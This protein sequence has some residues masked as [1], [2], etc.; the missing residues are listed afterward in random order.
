MQLSVNR[1]WRFA[2]FSFQHTAGFL[3]DGFVTLTQHHVDY[4]LCTDNL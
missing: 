1:C 4:R 3:G 2:V